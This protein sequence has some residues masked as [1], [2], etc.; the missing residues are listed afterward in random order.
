MRRSRHL[1]SKLGVCV[2]GAQGDCDEAGDP[3]RPIYAVRVR[4]LL[5]IA[6]IALLGSG[7]TLDLPTAA[8]QTFRSSRP[9]LGPAVKSGKLSPRLSLLSTAGSFASPHG[10]SQRA[11][12][13][14]LGRRQ[15]D[16]A[17]R[18]AC[19]RRDPHLGHLVERGGPTRKRGRADRQH[20]RAVP[21]HYGRGCPSTLASIAA[22][23]SVEYVSE[24]LAPTVGNAGEAPS[25]GERAA[26]D[27][28]RA[29][30]VRG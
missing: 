5:V 29:D 7:S 24:V 16:P 11:E 13:S 28:C 3:G 23:S 14:D 6:T 9:A 4:V 10:G 1:S 20:Q 18:R 30:R 15:P 12:P 26:S 27:A 8:A 17:S 2:A 22:D 21:H 19:S 25:S